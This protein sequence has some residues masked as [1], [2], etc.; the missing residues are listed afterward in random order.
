[1]AD[2]AARRDKSTNMGEDRK[3]DVDVTPSEAYSRVTNPERFL[4]L[5]EAAVR[6]LERLALEFKVERTEGHGLDVELEN[7]YLV[8]RPSIRMLPQ[9][10][11]AAPLVVVFSAFPGL[12][13]RF[14]HWCMIAF[15]N[16]GCD[17][18]NENAEG[19]IERLTSHIN[20]VTASRFRE[21]IRIHPNGNAWRESEFWSVGA[22]SI[23][24][25]S[26]L[27]PD[28]ARQLVAAGDQLSHHWESWP[29][30]V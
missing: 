3:D 15:P 5:H 23:Q 6:L 20:D 24:Q 19:E 30:R 18:C 9:K 7:R 29:R 8:A 25:S 26:R 4:V 16:C 22:H 17:A 12:H 14:G 1:M 27:N 21:D 28:C 2:R 10:A 11:T 13:I